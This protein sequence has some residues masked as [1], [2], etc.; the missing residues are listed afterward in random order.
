MDYAQIIADYLKM[1]LL[2]PD[3]IVF[4]SRQNLPQPSSKHIYVD[5]L[6]AIPVGYGCIVKSAKHDDSGAVIDDIDEKIRQQYA[7]KFN[8]HVYNFSAIESAE[9][10]LKLN[11]LIKTSEVRKMFAEKGVAIQ[12]IKS[13]GDFGDMYN[14]QWLPRSIFELTAKAEFISEN[15][16]RE[17]KHF[18][19]ENKTTN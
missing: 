7:L 16:L 9:L 1:I 12:Y 13:I 5:F 6:K 14:N 19:V 2:V 3:K 11:N 15:T 10:P 17:I 18:Q 4:T 8:I